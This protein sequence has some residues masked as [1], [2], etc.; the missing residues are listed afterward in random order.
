MSALIITAPQAMTAPL[1]GTPTLKL[2]GDKV[3]LTSDGFSGPAGGFAG[4]TADTS[5]GGSPLKWSTIGDTHVR[6]DGAGRAAAVGAVDGNWFHHFSLPG[7][8][9]RQVEVGFTLVSK[10]AANSLFLDLFRDTTTTASRR[11]RL[12]LTTTTATVVDMQGT[13]STTVPGSGFAIANGD[14][15]RI[16]YNTKLG[17]I[18]IV[19]NDIPRAPLT[20]LPAS[21]FTGTLFGIAGGD[22]TGAVM[23]DFTVTET[24]L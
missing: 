14:R 13:S 4:R 6:I 7:T 21:P 22:V 17:T 23:D 2:V 18:Q 15:L 3:V 5:K 20:Y 24:L 12:T 11:L 16:S 9:P 10:T 1:P 19:V 8:G